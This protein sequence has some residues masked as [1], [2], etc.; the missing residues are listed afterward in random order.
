MHRVR[1]KHSRDIQITDA[2]ALTVAQSHNCKKKRWKTL[3]IELVY[4]SLPSST[5][6][7]WKDEKCIASFDSFYFVCEASAKNRNRSLYAI[8]NMHFGCPCTKVDSLH[9]SRIRVIISFLLQTLIDTV[10]MRLHCKHFAENCEFCARQTDKWIMMTAHFT[11]HYSH[12]CTLLCSCTNYGIIIIIMGDDTK[13]RAQLQWA[14]FKQQCMIMITLEMCQFSQITE[15]N[16][17]LCC[18]D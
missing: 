2:L 7:G 4:L 15:S 13:F 1:C 12:L 6:S 11:I 5:K 16:G 9:W 17:K 3:L 10:M 14:M 8:C 18:I